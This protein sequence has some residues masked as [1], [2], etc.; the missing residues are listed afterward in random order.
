MNTILSREVSLIP[1][2]QRTHQWSSVYKWHLKII[3]NNNWEPFCNNIFCVNNVEGKD[4][5]F[6]CSFVQLRNTVFLN[7]SHYRRAIDCSKRRQSIALSR[8]CPRWAESSEAVHGRPPLTPRWQI[9]R[10]TVSV[11]Y[12]MLN[13]LRYFIATSPDLVLCLSIL[14]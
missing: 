7:S 1:L 14:N 12:A 9:L 4:V 11:N 3:L 10:L 2:P 5:I 8:R 6:H 13:N